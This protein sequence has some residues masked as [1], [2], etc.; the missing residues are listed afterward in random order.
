[1]SIQ[2]FEDILCW[3]KARSLAVDVYSIFKSNRDYG[4][5]DQIQRATVS[6]SNNIAEGYERKGNKEFSK[7][8]YIARGSCGEVR[9][10]FYIALELGY[11]DSQQFKSLHGRANEISRMIYGLISKL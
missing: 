4:F 9:S 10:M 11:I 3:Q 2:T 1:M 5:K 6:I 7:F 8:L